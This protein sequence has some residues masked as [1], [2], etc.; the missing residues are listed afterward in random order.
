MPVSNSFQ[1]GVALL[2]DAAV[3]LLRRVVAAVGLRQGRIEKGAAVR[4]RPGDDVEVVRR[5]QHRPQ[6]AHEVDGAPG[7]AVDAKPLAAAARPAP[8]AATD[9]RRSPR[10]RRIRAAAPP[11]RVRARTA[12]APLRPP[13]RSSRRPGPRAPTSPS[14]AEPRLRAGCSCPERSRRGR[15]AGPPAAPDRGRGS[16][17]SRRAG[18]V[19]RA[20]SAAPAPSI[21]AGGRIEAGRPDNEPRFKR[22]VMQSVAKHLQACGESGPTFA[23]NTASEA[24]GL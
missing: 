10:G 9:P 18:C 13:S 6:L 24:T 4:G 1:C 3:A 19:G 21:P 17:E 8:V 23:D 5:E 14:P 15:A 7:D 22:Q 2:Q 16:Y 12:A 20:I 11:R